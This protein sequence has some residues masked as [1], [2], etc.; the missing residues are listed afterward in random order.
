[1]QD[2]QDS[3]ATELGLLIASAI[4]EDEVARLCGARTSDRPIV[5]T[6]GMAISVEW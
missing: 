3:L 6:R 4:L 5:R 1:M 2:S